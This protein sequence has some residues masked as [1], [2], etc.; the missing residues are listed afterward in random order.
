MSELF[1]SSGKKRKNY[2]SEKNEIPSKYLFDDSFN[3]QRGGVNA[4]N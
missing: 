4:I 2:V 3:E 1:Q